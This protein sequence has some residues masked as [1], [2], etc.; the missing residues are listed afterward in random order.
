[1]EGPVDE[2]RSLPWIAEFEV[3][4]ATGLA[5]NVAILM[6]AQ[7]FTFEGLA[8]WNLEASPTPAHAHGFAGGRAADPS[9][10]AGGW[11]ATPRP[12]PEQSS[13]PPRAVAPRGH[14]RQASRCAQGPVRGSRQGPCA[15]VGRRTSRHVRPNRLLFLPRRAEAQA[16]FRRG[17]NGRPARLLRTA[18]HERRQR[19]PGPARVRFRCGGRPRNPDPGPRGE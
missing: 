1:A 14:G 12:G 11:H 13:C 3:R 10:P 16:P 8:A 15:V 6:F 4:S 18:G 19:E 17:R 5:K 7:A 9:R 2:V